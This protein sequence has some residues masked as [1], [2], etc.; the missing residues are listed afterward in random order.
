MAFYLIVG[1]I[2]AIA[3]C[4]FCRHLL[5]RRR[6]AGIPSP[7]SYPLLGHVPIT[8]PDVEGFVD[9]IMGMAHLY[10]NDPRMVVFWAGPVPSVMLY[11]PELAESIL[12][13]SKHLNKG[14]FYDF[15]R[16]WLGDGLLTRYAGIYVFNC[17]GFRHLTS[18]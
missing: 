2:F 9:Q 17:F 4:L 5:H 18:V 16:P 10:P 7:R 14:I 1:F 13:S 8:R 11:S 6:F 3:I 15:L 12:T